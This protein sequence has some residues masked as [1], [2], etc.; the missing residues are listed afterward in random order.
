MK[1]FN[2]LY[3]LF[4]ILTLTGCQKEYEEIN[5]TEVPETDPTITLV[6]GSITGTIIDQ[7]GNKIDGA[8]VQVIVNGTVLHET[9]TSSDGE[10][11]FNDVALSPEKNLIKAFSDSYTANYTTMTNVGQGVQLIMDIRIVKNEKIE[12]FVVGQDINFVGRNISVNIPSESVSNYSSEVNLA[13]KYFNFSKELRSLYGVRDALQADGTIAKVNFSQGVYVIGEHSNSQAAEI[14]EGFTYQIRFAPLTRDNPREIEIWHFNEK[15]ILWKRQHTAVL[16]DNMYVFDAEEF[17]HFAVQATQGNFLSI[18]LDTSYISSTNCLSTYTLPDVDAENS[19]IVWESSHKEGDFASGENLE[20]GVEDSPVTLT[21]Y[22]T[23]P[24]GITTSQ[25]LEVIIEDKLAPLAVCNSDISVTI[26]Q[27]GNAIVTT[28]DVDAGS[29]DN[30][31]SEFS[32]LIGLEP[33]GEFKNELSFSKSQL[34]ENQFVVLQAKDQAGNASTCFSTLQVSDDAGPTAICATNFSANISSSGTALINVLQLDNGSSDECTATTDLNF[35]FD[36]NEVITLIQFT[37]TDDAN[38]DVTMWVSDEA[39]NK[40]SCQTNI[41]INDNQNV[42]TD[43]AEND[44]DIKP[45]VYCNPIVRREIEANGE[46]TVRA[47]EFDLG[48]YDNLSE[49]STLRFSFEQVNN[50]PTLTFDCDD[51][52]SFSSVGLRMWVWDEAGNKDFCSVTLYLE[53]PNGICSGNTDLPPSVVCLLNLSVTLNSD[54]EAVLFAEDFDDGSVSPLGQNLTFT[55]KNSSSGKCDNNTDDFNSTVTFCTENIGTDNLVTLRVTD[56]DGRFTDCLINVNV[57]P[58]SPSNNSCGGSTYHSLVIND[59]N[60]RNGSNICIPITGKN[61]SKVASVQGAILWD[62]NVL[63]YTHF[64][65]AALKDGTGNDNN[66]SNGIFRYVWLDFT[67]ANP[68]TVD[69]GDVLFELCFDVVGSANENTTV[70]FTDM[71]D[72]RVEIT[73]N[74]IVVPHCTQEGLFKVN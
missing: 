21:V 55:A 73:S 37:C 72:M 61:F 36:E 62:D 69:D 20:F 31:C 13:A 4:V 15:E 39:G 57:E 26:N 19:T 28:E 1:K 22:V 27:E 68:V 71:P 11:F 67:A 3:I 56:E 51:L 48:S 38:Q 45:F 10:Y 60:A 8:T 5:T 44:D 42:C 34:Q 6:D 52:Q 58:E 74:D 49:Q 53:D 9:T 14:K 54:G 43:V 66:A 12:S 32:M 64:N 24:D 23:G 17:G 65:D 35:S 7:E 63:S 33:D 2:F 29:H 18:E 40:S 59:T 16:T 30:G 46:F 50:E 41:T 70:S 25:E 47:D